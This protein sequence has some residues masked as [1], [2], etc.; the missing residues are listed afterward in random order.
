MRGTP[1]EVSI[2]IYF[3]NYS[4]DKEK[5]GFEEKLNELIELLK[6]YKN[7]ADNKILRTK[8][9][10]EKPHKS[11]SPE[12]N[13][14]LRTLPSLIEPIKPTVNQNNRFRRVPS[15][16]LPKNYHPG[17]APPWNNT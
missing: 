13:E 11:F 14:F 1:A 8:F 6:F 4:R 7:A 5:E 12:H 9:I 10:L 17:N 3:N 16:K 15:P 2:T